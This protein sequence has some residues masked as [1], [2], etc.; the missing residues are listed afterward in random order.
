[1]KGGGVRTGDPV[2]RQAITNAKELVKAA[3][4]KKGIK[5]R[6]VSAAELTKLADAAVEK[7]PQL[8]EQARKQVEAQRAAVASISLEI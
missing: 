2:R 8:L 3:L 5:V 1:M 6:E 7:H 4:A